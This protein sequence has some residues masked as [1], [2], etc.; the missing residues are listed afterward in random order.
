MP[1]SG[2]PVISARRYPHPRRYGP[3]AA[4]L[5]QL[6]GAA[7]EITTAV[8]S[9]TLGRGNFLEVI[10]HRRIQID[11]ILGAPTAIFSIRPGR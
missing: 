2:I 1:E 10:L 9:S 5:D 3:A 4:H 7:V 6:G 8:P 11:H